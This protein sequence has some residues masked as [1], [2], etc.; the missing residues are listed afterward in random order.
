M[1]F[2]PTLRA[3]NLP[4]YLRKKRLIAGRTLSRWGFR[5]R[6]FTSGQ[7]AFALDRPLSGMT[8][9]WQLS[10]HSSLFAGPQQGRQADPFPQVG[11]FAGRST[12]SPTA[13][14]VHR[15]RVDGTADVMIPDL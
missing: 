14:E 8:F 9:S 10:R 1:S 7:R 4:M 2:S 3:L 15:G 11:P 12:R 6:T 5:S 13:I